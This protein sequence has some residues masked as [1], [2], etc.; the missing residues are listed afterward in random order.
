MNA[1]SAADERMEIA[2]QWLLRLEANDFDQRELAGWLEWYG[3]DPRNREAFEHMQRTFESMRALPGE[4]RES[5]AQRMEDARS[6][7]AFVPARLKARSGRYRVASTTSWALAASFVAL[8][9]GLAWTLW[10][11]DL[12]FRAVVPAHTAVYHTERAAHRVVNLPDGSEVRLGAASSVSLNYTDETRYLV[13]EGGEAF[14][15]VAR[16]LTRPFIVQAGSVRVRAVGTAFNVRRAEQRVVVTVSDGAVDVARDAELAAKD[17]SPR[18]VRVGAGEQATLSSDRGA[19]SLAAVDSDAA[20]AWQSG[21]L[22]FVNEPLRAVLA[23]VN[24]Y[25]ARKLLLADGSLDTLT[26]TGTVEKDR[27]EEWLEALEDVFPLR[28][29]S[30]GGE[31]I[32][33]QKR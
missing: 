28:A 22:E 29:T 24:R 33:L 12:D 18:T 4:Q 25:S 30:I 32:L 11:S 26:Y 16:D 9:L 1:Q 23:T 5:I 3:A 13:L 7:G 17:S 21:R 10:R 6:V 20:L 2:G 31:T 15:Q 27:V 14:F 8:G 19:L